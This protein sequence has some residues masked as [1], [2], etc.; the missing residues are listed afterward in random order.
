MSARTEQRSYPEG[1]RV[2]ATTNIAG[3]ADREA[4]AREIALNFAAAWPTQNVKLAISYA[5]AGVLAWSQV[6]ALFGRGFGLAR[7]AVAS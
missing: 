3:I 5:E 6:A 2:M 1:Q 4:E 7:R